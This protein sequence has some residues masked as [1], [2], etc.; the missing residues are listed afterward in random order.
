MVAVSPQATWAVDQA[1]AEP[2]APGDYSF[3]IK[4]SDRERSYLVHLPPQ[5]TGRKPLPVVLNFHGATSNGRQQ[6]KYS[7]M[8]SAADR[9]G[10]IA[11][12]P[13]GTGR[14]G[15]LTWNA[16]LCCAY[17]MF[18]R[19][20]DVGFVRALVEDLSKRTA[21]DHTRIYATGISNGAM[22]SYRLAAEASDL[23]AAIAPVAGAMVLPD[24]S[25]TRPIAIMHI[26]SV[27]DPFADYHG[28]YGRSGK[29]GHQMG[30]PDVEKM[31]ARWRAFDKCPDEPRVGPVLKGTPGTSDAGNS[32]TQ[33]VWG[34]CAERTE[35]VLWKLTGSGH[36]WPGAPQVR[37]LGRPTSLFDA[38]QEIWDFFTKF[39]LPLND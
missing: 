19:V 35:I 28:G 33:Y 31:L 2:L 22:M 11:V 3:S 21:I 1:A 34:P 36:V 14:L 12:Y 9:F 18:H 4:H 20:D 5:A 23:I 25:P 32:A 10:F 17:A 26:H 29:L 27:D 38:N 39:S 15:L 37:F 7:G 8:D 13:N 16:G 30:N 6:E 24:F